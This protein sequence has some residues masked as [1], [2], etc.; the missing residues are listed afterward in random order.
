MGWDRG[1]L[2]NS[3]HRTKGNATTHIPRATI[4]RIPVILSTIS[5]KLNFQEQNIISPLKWTCFISKPSMS[6]I[7]T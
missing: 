5:L 4:N 2:P 7:G 3:I 6:A 1:P